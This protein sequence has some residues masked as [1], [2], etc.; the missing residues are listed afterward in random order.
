MVSRADECSIKD[1]DLL[2]S[3]RARGTGYSA[4]EI[5]QEVMHSGNLAHAMSKISSEVAQTNEINKRSTF[6]I[7][8]VEPVPEES[9]KQ[10]SPTNLS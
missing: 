8:K 3:V 2:P 9:I 5:L 1:E 6:D 7:S 10:E 4:R